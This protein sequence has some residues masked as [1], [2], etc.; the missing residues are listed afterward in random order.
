MQ[1]SGFYIF[2]KLLYVEYYIGKDDDGEYVSDIHLKN[3]KTWEDIKM[4]EDEYDFFYKKCVEH[5]EDDVTG[6]IL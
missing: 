1:H 3:S 6:V 4:E 5:F 2:N